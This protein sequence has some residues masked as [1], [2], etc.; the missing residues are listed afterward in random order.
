[1]NFNRFCVNVSI[2]DDWFYQGI[3][4][5]VY[6]KL[7]VEINNVCYSEVF[8]QPGTLVRIFVYTVYIYEILLVTWR[9]KKKT[10][11]NER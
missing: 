7:M 6:L 11:K 8:L 10:K 5:M 4:W 2:V 3:I 9:K 1:L